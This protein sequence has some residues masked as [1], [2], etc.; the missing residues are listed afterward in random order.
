MNSSNGFVCFVFAA[1]FLS[2]P[3]SVGRFV[4][5]VRTSISSGRRYYDEIIIKDLQTNTQ[6]PP[7]IYEFFVGA[8]M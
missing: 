3:F 2:T 7:D 5:H 4:C 8:R 1:T 6:W